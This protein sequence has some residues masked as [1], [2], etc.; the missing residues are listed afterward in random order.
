MLRVHCAAEKLFNSSNYR[1]PPRVFY[2]TVGKNT[3][4]KKGLSQSSS[5]SSEV[6]A[7]PGKTQDLQSGNDDK[8][9]TASPRNKR[10]EQTDRSSNAGSSSATYKTTR[11]VSPE[12]KVKKRAPWG[13]QQLRDSWSIDAMTKGD[14]ENMS[15][16]IHRE[17]R[18]HPDEFRRA[19]IKWTA[20]MMIPSLLLGAFGGYY[21]HTGRP[22]WEGDPQ[23]LL[24][25][26][27]QM[28]TSPRSKLYAYRIEGVE[29][30]PDHV[31][32]YREKHWKKRL[33]LD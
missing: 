12:I 31:R 3:S 16:R 25:M 30:L 6:V 11:R 23:Y 1:C 13:M 21:Y 14:K 5:S 26:V 18:Y 17:Y 2:T 7:V 8:K 24:N 29:E 22:L 27:R 19:H 33:M 10:S 15:E 20:F 4:Q 9:Y 32:A 28:D